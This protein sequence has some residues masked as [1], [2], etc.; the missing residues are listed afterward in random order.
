LRVFRWLAASAVPEWCDL[1]RCGWQLLD[2]HADLRAHGLTLA[3][4]SAMDAEAWLAIFT[5]TGEERRSSVMLIG[6]A[7]SLERAKLLRFGFADVLDADLALAEVEA[8]AMR[9]LDCSKLLPAERRFGALRLD[10]LRRDGFIGAKALGLHPREFALLWRLAESPGTAVS[11]RQLLADVWQ[12]AFVPETNS[13]AV[14]VFRLRAKLAALG[15]SCLVE[16]DGEGG[17]RL[18]GSDKRDQTANPGV[19]MTG[20]DTRRGIGDRRP[21]GISRDFLHEASTSS[22]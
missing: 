21:I 11:K 16:A 14:H 22:K 6:V 5:L 3:L 17:Y 13:L 9:A 15:A 12:M 1:R 18:N 4:P 2:D 10:L 8:R 19:A 7:N 20:L